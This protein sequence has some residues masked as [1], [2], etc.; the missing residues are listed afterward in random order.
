MRNHTGLNYLG[1]F[2]ALVAL[3]LGSCQK[4]DVTGGLGMLPEEDLIGAFR[5]DTVTLV[6]QTEKEDSLRTDELSVALIGSYIDPVFG[7]VNATTVTQVRLST[8]SVTFPVAYAVDSVVLVLEYDGYLYGRQGS[9]YFVVNEVN[10]PLV[11][12]DSYYSNRQLAVFPENLMREGQERQTIRPSISAVNSPLF[13]PL[14]LN[15]KTSL[16]EKLM[17]PDDPTALT[18]DANFRSYFKGLQVGTLAEPN[19]GVFN[20]DLTDVASR[21]VVYYRDFDGQ[22]PDTTTYTFSITSD[23]A[24][25]TRFDQYYGGTALAGIEEAPL[26]NQALCYLQ[27]GSGTK[28]RIDIPY[29]QDFNTFDRRTINGAQLIVPFENDTK[30]R[31]QDQLALL[32]LD[33]QGVLR[34][35]PDQAAQTIGGLGDFARNEYRFRIARYIQQVLNGEITSQGLYLL[36]TRAG[37]TVNRVVCHGPAHTLGQPFSNMRLVLTFTAD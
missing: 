22:E 21:L 9:P 27:A 5:T 15:L 2:F 31:A 33:A 3:A 12:Q 7:V 29:L 25:F 36:S 17:S 34:A 13:P 28:V 37:V 24:R 4:P 30:F 23:C 20:V 1:L 18:S 32:Y 10:E 8:S 11:L 19:S 16:G 35:L 14:R 6:I 26:S